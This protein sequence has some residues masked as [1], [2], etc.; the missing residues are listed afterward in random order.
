M[1]LTRLETLEVRENPAG[2]VL[3][4]P[5]RP[6]PAASRRRPRRPARA[7]GT[8]I[9]TPPPV[10]RDGYSATPAMRH[11]VFLPCNEP[12]RVPPGFCFPVRLDCLIPLT[13][14][15]PRVFDHA[16]SA[17]SRP[18]SAGWPGTPSLPC[19]PCGRG[20]CGSSC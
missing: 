11:E 9:P 17:H 3:G 2:P 1:S 7:P 8:V 19:G 20:S 16:P 18:P 15:V 10:S 14:Q 12:R 5:V 4:R 6:A 13:P